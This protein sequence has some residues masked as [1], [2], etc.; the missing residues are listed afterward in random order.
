M[1]STKL[2]RTW[3]FWAL[4]LAALAVM[5]FSL[6]TDTG[7]ARIDTSAAQGLITGKKVQSAQ[8]TTDK[9]RVDAH[10]FYER[11]GYVASHEGMKR[12]LR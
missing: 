2:R 3:V 6:T 5:L 1:N 12:P 11:L 8:L 9:R 4:G 10:R 7:Y